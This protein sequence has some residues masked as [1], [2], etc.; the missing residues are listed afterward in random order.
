[1]ITR[2]ADSVAKR[3]GRDTGSPPDFFRERIVAVTGAG[4]G[5]GREL[6]LEVSRR[7]GKVALADLDAKAVHETRRLCADSDSAEAFEFD[8]CAPDAMT[9]FAAH[10]VDRFGHVDVLVTCAGI[11]HFGT[12]ESTPAT[13]FDT[14]IRINYLGIVHAVKAFLPHLRA[15]GHPARIATV[16]SAVGLIGAAGNS[17]YSA[18]KFAIRGFTE[19]L[20]AELANTNVAVTCVHPGG[21]RTPIARTALS[22]PDVDRT[23]AITRF[24]HRIARTDA[25]E[26]A[27]IIVAGIAS[28]RPRVLIGADA[29]LADVAARIAGPHYDRVI[30]AIAKL[31]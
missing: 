10:A 13:D 1:M 28:G 11:L 16:S 31:A 15:T 9:R 12:V 21:I 4:S 22:A 14:V 5:I 17:A 18:S 8:V 3:L 19:S 30:K 7:G 25:D 29:R 26:A 2:W 20:R 27:R 6:A 24:E 23:E